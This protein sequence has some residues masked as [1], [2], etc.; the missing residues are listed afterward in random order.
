MSLPISGATYKHYKG[1]NYTVLACGKDS[2]TLEDLVVYK[3]HRT[4]QV[5]VRAAGKFGETIQT[6]AG[7]V[8]RFRLVSVPATIIPPPDGLY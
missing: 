3:S 8:E 4:D 2:E 6:P 7:L 5:W 1:D